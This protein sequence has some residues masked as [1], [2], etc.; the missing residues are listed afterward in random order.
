VI[1]GGKI[2]EHYEKKRSFPSEI[3]SDVPECKI[4][5]VEKHD[6]QLSASGQLSLEFSL[7]P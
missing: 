7:L 1:I 3:F 5:L 6:L 4:N 2:V